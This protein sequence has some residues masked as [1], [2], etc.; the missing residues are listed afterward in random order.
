MFTIIED[1]ANIAEDNGAYLVTI[2]ATRWFTMNVNWSEGKEVQW[3]H[4][5]SSGEFYFKKE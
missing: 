4:M 3:V 5:D 2:S 1:V